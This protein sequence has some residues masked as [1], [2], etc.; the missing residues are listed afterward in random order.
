MIMITIQLFLVYTKCLYDFKEVDNNTIFTET[1][2]Y[3]CPPFVGKMCERE[4]AYQRN[5][6]HYNLSRKFHENQS[7]DP[8]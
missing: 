3:E 6:I 4:V 2:N 7:S 1:I 8:K 5:A